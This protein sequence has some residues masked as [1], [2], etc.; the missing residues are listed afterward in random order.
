MATKEFRFESN[1]GGKPVLVVVGDDGLEVVFWP[2]PRRVGRPKLSY[3]LLRDFWSKAQLA[4]Y[5]VHDS[6][7]GGAFTLVA[8]DPEHAR[9]LGVR[10]EDACRFLDPA[11]LPATLRMSL[12]KAQEEA[13][14]YVDG[15]LV[16][17][18]R[19]QERL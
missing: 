16:F 8:G 3:V 19:L 1:D 9:E 15:S 11:N 14:D 17:A 13:W 6:T 7:G 5:N 10:W 4:K 12:T 18:R 2:H